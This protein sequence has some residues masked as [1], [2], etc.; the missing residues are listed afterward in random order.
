MQQQMR[1]MMEH[2]NNM[3]KQKKIES[4]KDVYKLPLFIEPYCPFMVMT[5]DKQRAFDFEWEAW[6]DYDRKFDESTE[7]LKPIIVDKIN[8]KD[9]KIEHL[10]NFKYDGDGMI[11]AT[12]DADG[13]EYD[14]MLIRGWGH[15]TGIG[16]LHLDH[17]F[18]AKLQD[19]FAKYIVDTLNN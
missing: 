16:A 19:D 4:W 1:L 2:V 8:G 7:K 6:E 13:K 18:A 12:Y 3:S 9:V 15:L 5:Y 10:S 14:I 17:E 11:M